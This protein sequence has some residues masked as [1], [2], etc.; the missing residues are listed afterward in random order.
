VPFGGNQSSIVGVVRMASGKKRERGTSRERK[1]KMQYTRIYVYIY[2]YMYV[3]MYG[4]VEGRDVQRQAGAGRRAARGGLYALDAAAIAV[5]VAL[6]GSFC[7]RSAT[8]GSG[9]TA[10][11]ATLE[12]K[13]QRVEISNAA[14]RVAS[15]ACGIAQT[16]CHK[17][18]AARAH[19]HH[20][21]CNRK[22]DGEEFQQQFDTTCKR[23]R[24][25]IVQRVKRAIK[26][27]CAS[28]K[29]RALG[30]I[31]KVGCA[32]VSKTTLVGGGG[33]IRRL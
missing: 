17:H 33:R 32:A 3:C 8:K 21:C 5:A 4:L 15:S 26:D 1:R 22:V 10:D 23:Q 19:Q 29:T 13:W 7:H 20:N 16:T 31:E 2:I 27:S 14:D 6:T 9:E 11:L 30:I 25:K 28:G 24:S 18:H 12:Q